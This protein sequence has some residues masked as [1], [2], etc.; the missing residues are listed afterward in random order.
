[1]SK[2]KKE[3]T[4][5]GKPVEPTIEV[6]KGWE[7]VGTLTVKLQKLYG[8][9]KRKEAAFL[10]VFS[11]LY[12]ETLDAATFIRK[13]A[14]TCEDYCEADYRFKDEIAKSFKKIG[15]SHD[16]KVCKGWKV[17]IGKRS[18][19]SPLFNAFALSWLGQ[20][21]HRPAEDLT[22]RSKKRKKP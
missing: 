3:E 5:K 4:G 21:G 10:K 6:P 7:V 18:A 22:G 12:D 17:A 13:F 16:L 19:L 15:Y 8:T 1:M 11:A 2:K 9:L 14:E 20:L